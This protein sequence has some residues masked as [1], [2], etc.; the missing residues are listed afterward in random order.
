MS[1]QGGI[2]GLNFNFMNYKTKNI[3]YEEEM[4]SHLIEGARKI[5]DAVRITM[6]S[7]G[8]NVIFEREGIDPLI[9]NDGVRIAREV[10]P[11]NKFEKLAADL[12]RQASEKTNY[13]AGDGTSLTVVLAYAILK[14]GLVK[15]SNGTNPMVLKKEIKEAVNKLVSDIKT[16][17]DT[18]DDDNN[19]KQVATISSSSEEVGQSIATII[20]KLGKDAPITVDTGHEVGV[21]HKIV[22]GMQFSKGMI[23]NHFYTNPVKMRYEAEDGCHVLVVNERLCTF[24]DVADILETLAVGIENR[25]G[26][27]DGKKRPRNLLLIVE[28]MELEALKTALQNKIKMGFNICCVQ[29]PNFQ[30]QRIE[31][32]QD[33]AILTG[34]EFIGDEAALHLDR[35]EYEHFGYAEKV[36]V[37]QFNTTITDGLGDKKQIK[38]R[39]SEIEAIKKQTHDEFNL[40][41]L[42]ERIGKLKGGVGV[43]EVMA[44]TESENQDLLM[45]IEDAILATKS[46]IAE[47]V[48]P[49]GGRTLHFLGEL[50]S[51]HH[52][53]SGADVL[54]KAVNY[55]IKQII[56]NAGGN[57]DLIMGKLIDED[58]D[59]EVGYNCD[60]NSIVNLEEAG[61]IDPVKVIREALENASSIASMLLTTECAMTIKNQETCKTQTK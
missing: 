9:L 39:I 45:R 36:I 37:D 8:R 47:G 2:E 26:G 34:G 10:V 3:L 21:K 41:K 4:R 22:T 24:S 49:G 17:A 6:G 43:L 11:S 40:E 5:Y 18:L 30:N 48:V 50:I 12:I 33:I 7:R 52:K 23:T 32:M 57:A 35:L 31:F 53:S 58:M 55:P 38:N 16:F 14:E 46:A 51:T 1:R 13:N 19:I 54:K 27:A 15:I 56:E 60:T 28:D 59:M 29:A 44:K 25:G 20:K 42:S 61:V